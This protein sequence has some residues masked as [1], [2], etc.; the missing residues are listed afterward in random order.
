MPKH[1]CLAYEKQ[2][3]CYSML[4]HSQCFLF[5]LLFLWSSDID[6]NIQ[7]PKQSSLELCKRFL[8]NLIF[9]LLLFLFLLFIVL[10][11]ALISPLDTKKILLRKWQSKSYCSASFFFPHW[12]CY[13]FIVLAAAYYFHFWILDSSFSGTENILILLMLA[14]SLCSS[15][16]FVYPRQNVKIFLYF[17]KL[18]E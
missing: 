4:L 13:F 7:L 5:P 1:N 15:A 10:F 8:S 11:S 6:C 2:G 18:F 17:E 3:Q 12:C 14:Y 16:C 9:K